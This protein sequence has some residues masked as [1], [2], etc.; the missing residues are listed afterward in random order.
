[1]LLARIL[2]RER[3]ARPQCHGCPVGVTTAPDGSL[4]VTDDGSN[5]VWR[6][7]YVGK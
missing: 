5:S 7:N 2:D 1:M 6:I 4:L 3:C